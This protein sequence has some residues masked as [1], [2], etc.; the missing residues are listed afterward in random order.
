MPIIENPLIY[1]HDISGRIG[2]SG[3]IL[4]VW[5][6][7]ALINSLKMWISSRKG[8]MIH[9][10]RRGGYLIDWL[11]KSMNETN[12]ENL[13]MSIRDGLDQDFSPRLQIINLIVSPDTKKRQWNIYMEVFSPE[14]KLRA[15]LDERIKATL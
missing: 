4:Q 8:D 14:L 5:E 2:L 3:D 6:Q 1:D 15:V 9:E 7:D 13:E 12:I 10:P 11:T